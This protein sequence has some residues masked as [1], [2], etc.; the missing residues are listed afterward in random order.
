MANIN[1][2]KIQRTL[3]E[4]KINHSSTINYHTI[5][6]LCRKKYNQLHPNLQSLVHHLTIDLSSCRSYP[7]MANKN[8]HHTSPNT[9]TK[10]TQQHSISRHQSNSRSYKRSHQCIHL[11]GRTR[12]NQKLK[13]SKIKNLIYKKTISHIQ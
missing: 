1:I 8:K 10:N 13:S 2:H 4:D 5:P 9:E 11:E 12:R 3:Q 7:T 6:Q